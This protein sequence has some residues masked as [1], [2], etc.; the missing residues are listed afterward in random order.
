M[1]TMF[2]APCRHEVSAMRAPAV[3]KIDAPNALFH[4]A[5]GMAFADL[6]V[7]GHRETWPIRSK[8]FRG[9]LRRC[10]Y[11]QTGLPLG[12]EA[13]RATMDLFEADA[14]F[15]APQRTV[16]TRVAEHGGRL[17]LDLADE[18]WHAV[19][20]SRRGWR[21]I[22]RPPVRFRR[23]AGMLALPVPQRGGSIASLAS[24]LN[25]DSHDQLVLVVGWLLATLRPAGPYPLLA[26]VGEQGSAKSVLSKLLKTLIDPNAAPVRTLAR[27][28]REL[29]ITASH[30]QILAFDNLS[31]LPP[32]LSDALCR[33]ATGGAFAARRLYTDDEELLLAAARP[34]LFNAIE[35]VITRADLADRAI[36]LRLEAIDDIAR[37][38][39]RQIWREFAILHPR[40]LGALLDAVAHGLRA[41]PRMRLERLPR[42]ADFAAWVAACEGA[43]WPAGTFARAFATNHTDAVAS[44]IETDPIATHVAEIM[45]GQNAWTG[46]ANDLLRTRSKSRGDDGA[47]RIADWPKNPRALSGRLRR[48]QSLL[49]ALNIELSFTREGHAG[50]RT[51]RLT[52]TP[53]DHTAGRRDELMRGTLE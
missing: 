18:V 3:S 15:D 35:D 44:M 19:E 20:I 31:S 22:G 52:R 24:L 16:Y 46:T 10:H 34:V 32:W 12:A 49:R 9:W 28:E 33:I 42:M 7:N 43:L 36:T 45:A 27:D 23:P 26:V 39:E 17:Y 11:R 21:V 29:M 38:P 48:A 8:Q 37:R 53:K 4:T 51:I 13:L 40:I 47:A 30:N 6:T 14:Q 5:A 2:A 41:L 50:A 25:L 1:V